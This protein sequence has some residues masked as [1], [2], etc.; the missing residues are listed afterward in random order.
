LEAFKSAISQMQ[1]RD[2]TN[3]SDGW[4]TG[5]ECLAKSMREG[6][7]NRIVLL[8]DG[9]AN[10]G[11]TDP[12]QLARHAAELAK[13]GIVTSTV[14]IGDDYE[15]QILRAIA[16][17]GGGRLHDA[18]RGT[19]I[20][21]VLAGELGEIGRAAAQDVAVTLLVPATARVKLVGS[22]P[23][24]VG[25]GSLTVLA[26]TLLAGRPRH[27]VFRIALPSGR[28]DESLLFGVTA[29]G[30]S[31]TGAALE[32]TPTEVALKFAVGAINS[33]QPR[34]EAT[35]LIVAQTWH[36]DIVRT[37]ASMNRS[38]DRRH[39]RHYVERQ[40][41]YFERYC[42]G[43]PNAREL[44]R[45]ITLLRRNIDRSWDERTRKEM[46]LGSYLAE[47]NRV[48]HRCAARASWAARMQ[49]SNVVKPDSH[50]RKA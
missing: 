49:Q 13:R 47:A 25:I 29:R 40:L 17:N 3:L 9:Q 20:V 37:A 45:E 23:S 15:G 43:L 30:T 34:D 46:E 14:G 7:V 27:V 32:A 39:A 8:S 21:D 10:A 33:P 36:A 11:I 28:A 5:A 19:D 50:G 16:E 35:S 24:T 4:F 6:G 38:G 42:D 2:R 12:E 18:E 41:R 22:A 1:S 48:D 26:G 44:A 31:P